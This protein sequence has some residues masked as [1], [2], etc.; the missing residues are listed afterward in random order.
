MAIKM[1]VEDIPIEIKRKRIKNMYIYVKAPYGNVVA[2]VPLSASTTDINKFLVPR[3]NWIRKHREKFSNR[4]IIERKQYEEGDVV[5]VEGYPYN[6]KFVHT[7]TQ[8][9][10][11]V[12]DYLV[13]ALRN[14]HYPESRERVIREFLR[15]HLKKRV[16][17]RLHYYENATDLHPSEWQLKDMETR[18]GSCNVSTKKIWLNLKLAHMP[19][20][21]LDYILLHEVA[22]LKISGHGADFSAFLDRY[23]FDWRD[24]KK[25]LDTRYMEFI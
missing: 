14:G 1:M 7:P 22:H 5:F 11:I 4:Q 12:G 16:E 24:I 9:A 13:L 19:D 20:E 17:E 25:A 6:L 21:F 23:M 2:S 8:Y 18:W 15:D 10:Y 3:I